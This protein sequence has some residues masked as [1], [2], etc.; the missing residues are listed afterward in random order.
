MFCASPVRIRSRRIL[1]FAR[2]FLISIPLSLNL[3]LSRLVFCAVGM[4]FRVVPKYTLTYKCVQ[5]LVAAEERRRTRRQWSRRHQMYAVHAIGQCVFKHLP[6]CASTSHKREL[7]V[8][9]RRRC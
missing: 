3:S 5:P 2:V 9:G 1:F 6:K 8:F 7:L 4:E